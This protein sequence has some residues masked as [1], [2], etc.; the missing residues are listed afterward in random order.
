MGMV[1]LV[2]QHSIRKTEVQSS[3]RIPEAARSPK[4]DTVGVYHVGKA[5][6]LVE[7]KNR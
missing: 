2:K 6:P 1:E 7:R 4:R 5:A 3:S